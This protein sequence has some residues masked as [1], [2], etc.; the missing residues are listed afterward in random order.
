M[1][2]DVS[3]TEPPNACPATQASPAPFELVGSDLAEAF[4]EILAPSFPPEALP[5]RDAF[6]DPP[7]RHQI[8]GLR[9]AAGELVAAVCTSWSFRHQVMILTHFAVKPGRRGQDF[10]TQMLVAASEDW[11]RMHGEQ[12]TL[13]M[14]LPHPN[15]HVA[16]DEHGD[17]R[18]AVEFF[19][20]FGVAALNVPYFRPATAESQMAAPNL[21]LAIVPGTDRVDGRNLLSFLE[22]EYADADRD[23][24]W[25]LV[26][27]ALNGPSLPRV[28]LSA[29]DQLPVSGPVSSAA[30][31]A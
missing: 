21:I 25:T 31:A 17:P 8:L 1:F 29:F 14:E 3:T 2:L 10:G 7:G 12:W 30:A 11:S 15:H 19:R 22:A 4:D 6:L 23:G 13:L 5:S 24:P 18:R 28:P 20:R 26:A 27:D 16:S 9:D